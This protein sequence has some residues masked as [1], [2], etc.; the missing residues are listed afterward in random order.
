MLSLPEAG[1]EGNDRRSEESGRMG[2]PY[3]EGSFALIAG[4]FAT[5]QHDTLFSSRNIS[6]SFP[7]LLSRI[8][9]VGMP[10]SGKTTFG[11]KL[12]KHLDYQFLDLDELIAQKE[13]RNI[14]EIFEQ[15]GELYFRQAE[16][17]VLQNTFLLEKSLIATGGG[18]PCFADNMER[19]NQAGVSVW[20]QA[21][22]EILAERIIR[23]KSKRP[24]FA[25][26][27][28]TQILQIL[29]EKLTE[30]EIFYRKAR[31]FLSEPYPAWVELEKLLTL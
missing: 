5:A 31:I 8:F 18:T 6:Y 17:E 24:M 23:G 14:T 9:L 2:K 29:R 22:P 3:G 15:S 4:C 20:L 1:A 26:K 7:M 12:A 30:R 16:K 28:K 13:N 10:G 21:E 11:K 25:G 19:I 27:N